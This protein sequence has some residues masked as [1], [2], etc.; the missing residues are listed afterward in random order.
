MLGVIILS[1]NMLSVIMLNVFILS[2]VMLSV[3]AHCVVL[4]T[5]ICAECHIV[6]LC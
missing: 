3:V 5:E 1:L 4:K 2:T 6:L